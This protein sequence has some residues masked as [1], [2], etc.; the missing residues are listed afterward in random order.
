MV[1]LGRCDRK[2][3]EKGSS[4]AHNSLII[5]SDFAFLCSLFGKMFY[6][7]YESEEEQLEK[8]REDLNRKREK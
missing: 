7:V 5:C 2:K 8:W 3:S 6:D 4:N 1:L